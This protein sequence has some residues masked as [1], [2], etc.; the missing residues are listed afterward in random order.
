MSKYPK[1]IMKNN[2]LPVIEVIK[3]KFNCWL[4]KDLSIYDSILL[5]KTEG[6]S[7]AS[8][9]FSLLDVS[10]SI[11]LQLDKILFNMEK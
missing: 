9:M 7:R 11:C 3:K 6:M 10:K 5:S 1:E 2:L 4:A 8:Y